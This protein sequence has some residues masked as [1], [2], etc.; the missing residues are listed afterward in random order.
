MRGLHDH[1][2]YEKK[3]GEHFKHVILYVKYMLLVGNNMGLIKEVKM[4]LSFKFDMKDLDATNFIL[5]TKKKRDR[6][7]IRLWLSQSKYVEIGLIHF[8]MRD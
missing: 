2:V 8:N 7:D 1:Y 6:A 5:G 4:K 3:A